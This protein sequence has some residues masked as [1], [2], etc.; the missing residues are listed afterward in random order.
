MSLETDQSDLKLNKMF[1]T[2]VFVV[3]LSDRQSIEISS[4]HYLFKKRIISF[5]KL[6]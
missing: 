4:F 2:E 5:Y 3:A 6:I 1:Q